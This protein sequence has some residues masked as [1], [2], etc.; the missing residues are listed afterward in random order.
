ME[1]QKQD[2][3]RVFTLAAEREDS[4]PL[5]VYEEGIAPWRRGSPGEGGGRRR[6][7]LSPASLI[8]RFSPDHPHRPALSAPP[9]APSRG[10][11]VC[12]DR[13]DTVHWEHERDLWRGV[14]VDGRERIG[15]LALC[16]WGIATRG[17]A[18]GEGG[19][20]DGSPLPCRLRLWL[21]VLRQNTPTSRPLPRPPPTPYKGAGSEWR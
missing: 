8:E 15:P 1:E 9:P 21:N 20:G 6:L 17:G 13:P 19:G 18:D 10:R 2:F 11:A 3:D 5:A 7:P 16:R 14:H 4:L 12:G